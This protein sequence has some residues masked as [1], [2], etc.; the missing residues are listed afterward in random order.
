MRRPNRIPLT[1]MRPKTMRTNRVDSLCSFWVALVTIVGTLLSTPCEAQQHLHLDPP[2]S[3][4]GVVSIRATGFDPA[5]PRD[6]VLWRLPRGASTSQAVRVDQ[7]RSDAEGRFDFGQVPIP[8]TESSLYV[9]AVG[10]LPDWSRALDLSPL[11]PGPFVSSAGNDPLVITVIP[12]LFEGWIELRD[13]GTGRRFARRSV[14]AKVSRSLRFD[15]LEE[16]LPIDTPVIT[17][18]QVLDDGRR[19][20]VTVWILDDR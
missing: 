9:A 14:S 7:T 12:A 2:A 10:E 16:A 18:E 3:D 5:A 19:S 11:V 1:T 8:I 20:E 15:L 17:I 6:L 13:A 4:P